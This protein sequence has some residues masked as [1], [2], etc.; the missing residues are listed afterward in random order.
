MLKPK[1][2]KQRVQMVVRGDQFVVYHPVHGRKALSN[3]ETNGLYS[4]GLMYSDARRAPYTARQALYIASQRH[5][6]ACVGVTGIRRMSDDE[7][8]VHQMYR[9]RLA[10]GSFLSGERIIEPAIWDMGV[11]EPELLSRIH[12][13]T[14]QRPP[15]LHYILGL[16]PN[17]DSGD[18]ISE[19]LAAL[20]IRTGFEATITE[21]MPAAGGLYGGDHISVDEAV[22]RVRAKK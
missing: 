5:R 1:K 7:W 14:S 19:I 15:L 21:K 11:V 6:F 2:R 10:G 12:P 13:T 20:Q 8:G 22:S 9:S 18:R 17:G 3:D 4:L 16:S